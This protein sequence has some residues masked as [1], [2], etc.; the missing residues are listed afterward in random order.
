MKQPGHNCSKVGRIGKLHGYSGAVRIDIDG[1]IAF[2]K[3]EKNNE[4]VFLVI[5]QKPV[6]FFYTRWQDGGESIIVKFEDI[7][8]EEAAREL[9]GLEVLAP[10]KWVEESDDVS[11]A[12]LIDYTVVDS[13]LGKLGFISNYMENPG[14]TLLYMMLNGREVMI[15]FVEEFIND[16]DPD[17]QT[18]Y[19]SLPDGLVDL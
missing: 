11:A 7:D 19:T 12:A 2:S 3:P 13:V 8:T 17:T 1:D 9:I 15:P 6:P 18:L 16:I 4:P 14:Q 10:E 5:H